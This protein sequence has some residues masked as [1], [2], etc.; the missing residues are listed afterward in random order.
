MVI[1]KYLRT[2]TR[3]KRTQER[4]FVSMIIRIIVLYLLDQ[5]KHGLN[6]SNSTGPT[7]FE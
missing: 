7:P 5:F 2:Y 1:N 4:D 3:Y 6:I